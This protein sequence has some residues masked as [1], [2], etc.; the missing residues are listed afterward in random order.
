MIAPFSHCS[1]DD[2]W[3]CNLAPD[4]H[5]STKLIQSKVD[6][7][8]SCSLC[9][10]VLWLKTIPIK[11]T[12]FIWRA[13]MGHIPSV[14]A[15]KSRGVSIDFDIC[16]Y[17]NE[18]VEDSDHILVG[19]QATRITRKWILQ[20]R[21]IN[22]WHFTLTGDFLDFVAS[23]GHCPKKRKLFLTIFYGMLWWIWRSRNDGIFLNV[24]IPPTIVADNVIAMVFSWWKHRG[25][26]KILNGLIG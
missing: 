3:T 7:Y 19:C 9:P 5:F 18:I 20:W 22:D 14:M 10:R 8:P 17:C 23:W 21:G 25:Q 11:V 26:R 12:C 4:G 1:F 13:S 6:L 2:S 24:K 16:G 15:L